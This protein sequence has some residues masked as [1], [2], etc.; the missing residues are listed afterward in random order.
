MSADLL[1]DKPQLGTATTKNRSYRNGYF[2]LRG[3]NVMLGN[4]FGQILCDICEII[5]FIPDEVQS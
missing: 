4:G 2:Y 3:T 5:D 1:T